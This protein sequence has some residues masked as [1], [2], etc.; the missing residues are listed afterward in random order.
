[1]AQ[2]IKHSVD[3]ISSGQS[4][5]TNIIR[6]PVSSNISNIFNQTTNS[7]V[8]IKSNASVINP[9]AN[10]NPVERQS[11]RLGSG[12]LYDNEGHIVTST[13][14]ISNAKT[15]DVRFV[16]GNFYSANVTGK[17]VYSDLAVIQIDPSSLSQEHVQPLH[18]GD[19]SKLIVGEKVAAVGNPYGIANV[20]TDG[21]ISKLG[22]LLPNPDTGFS[23]PN[24]ILTDVPVNPG[25][26]GGPLFNMNGQV[27]GINS[28]TYSNSGDFAGISFAISS[29]TMQKIVPFLIKN[30]TYVHPSLGISGGKLAPNLAKAAGLPT[31]YKG[32]VVGT[33][34]PNSTAEQA[35]IKG[36]TQ[37]NNGRIHVG[38]IIIALNGQTI[39]QIDDLINYI[40]S[41]KNVGESIK[42]TIS[43]GGKI[44]DITAI[45]QAIP[46]ANPGSLQKTR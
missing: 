22:T 3:L 31:N 8:Q 9:D 2:T 11:V 7:V 18:V 19:S 25:S 39:R 38:D 45:L 42:L 34:Q 16:D 33:V 44:M 41:N 6:S 35:G 24:A 40:E 28:A 37:D 26:N 20:L 36:I 5:P 27:I 17:D 46:Q 30:G 32:I 4:S 1:M 23:I 12:F 43:R 13:N 14:V 29:N 21:I 15:V 10:G